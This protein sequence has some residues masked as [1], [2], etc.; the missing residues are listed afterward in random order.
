MLVLDAIKNCI[1]TIG[2]AAILIGYLIRT[3]CSVDRKQ[4]SSYLL[5]GGYC[6]ILVGYLLFIPES[7]QTIFPHNTA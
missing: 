3:F 5:L 2:I 1:A 7:I 6:I 4:L